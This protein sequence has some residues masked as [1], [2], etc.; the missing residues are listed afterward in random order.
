MF[1]QILVAYVY[2]SLTA[3]YCTGLRPFSMNH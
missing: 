2:I 3:T 1:L